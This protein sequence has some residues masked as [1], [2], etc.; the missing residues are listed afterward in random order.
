MLW[1]IKVQQQKWFWVVA[2]WTKEQDKK[3][4]KLNDIIKQG[5]QNEMG[6]IHKGE[7]MQVELV[8]W[9]DVLQGQ[10]HGTVE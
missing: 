1:A 6:F 3:I 2:E 4:R 5:T 8:R 9:T 10:L 7:R